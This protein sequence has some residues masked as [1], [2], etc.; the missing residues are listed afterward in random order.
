M[1]KEMQIRPLSSLAKVFPYKIV[2]KKCT[3]GQ[4]AAG[5]EISFQIAYRLTLQTYSKRPHR[6]EVTLGEN[7]DVSPE[8]FDVKFVPSFLAAYPTR[9]DDNY[10][11]KDGG[12]FPDPLV[13]FNNGEKVIAIAQSWQ[14]IWISLRIPEGHKACEDKITVRFINDKTGEVAEKCTFTLRVNSVD[15]PAPALK[16]TQWIHYDCI[17]DAHKVKIF[18]EEHW[19]LIEKYV[20]LAARHGINLVLTPVLTP[21]L[22]TAVGSERPT[23]QLVDIEYNNGEYSFDF[24]K[25]TR[26]VKL[27][28]G[29]GVDNFEISHMFTQW[30]AT[31]CPKVVAKVGGK[32][33]KIFGWNTSATSDEYKFF[34]SKLIPALIAHLNSLG[35]TNDHIIFHVSDEPGYLRHF[36]S[37]S[38]AANVLM[39]LIKGCKHMDAMSDFEFYEHGLVDIPVVAI[40]RPSMKFIED[41][42]NELWSYYCCTQ[43]VD[44]SNRFFAMPSPRTRILGVQMY[45]YDVKGFLHWGYN[46]YYSQFSIRKI[47]PWLETDADNAFAGG[48]AFSVYP[49]KDG[50]IPSLRLKTFA[51]ALDDIK[52]LRLVEAKIGRENTIKAIDEIA[53]QDISFTQ[54]PTDE[55]FFDKLYEFIFDTLEK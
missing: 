54:Y 19:T 46:F 2:G 40:G 1:A 29:V 31:C 25:L 50:A 32:N 3:F 26:F 17:A 4:V 35:V 10:I 30:G 49:Y 22:D 41:G 44:V 43:S 7:L 8:L 16:F 37:Y 20:G 36:E 48:D 34:L 52:L 38:A 21:P 28:K 11:T 5:Q 12:Y 45:K 51:N 13:P 33:K 9:C 6:V 42:V 15:L 27:V 14:S 18:S 23:V 47:D 39:P 24:S 53:G 55:K